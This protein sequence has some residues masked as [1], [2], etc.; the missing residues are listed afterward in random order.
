MKLAKKYA[1]LGIGIDCIN[2]EEQ[3]LNDLQWLNQVNLDAWW[4]KIG[5]EAVPAIPK[6]SLVQRPLFWIIC[7]ILM[8]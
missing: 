4:Q 7:I 5:K 6:R 3:L 2:S 8:V 1:F